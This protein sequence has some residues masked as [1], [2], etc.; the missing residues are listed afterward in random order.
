MARFRKRPVI[1]EAEQWWPGKHVPG[2]QEL[3]YDPGDGSTATATKGVIETLEGPLTVSPG[4][5]IIT[6][7]KG[8]KYPCKPDIFE[9]TYE[10]ADEP[11]YEPALLTRDMLYRC[12]VCGANVALH[13]GYVRR[14]PD[15][16][17]QAVCSEHKFEFSSGA[18]G[19]CDGPRHSRK[20]D[21]EV[22]R[23]GSSDD[24]A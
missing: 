11:A 19:G 15:G 7:V 5:W 23:D 21:E 16:T 3:V 22:T 2:V 9:A 4:D 6:G 12:C 18:A 8:E 24:A 14:L 10:P 20:S 17:V 13:G 1:I